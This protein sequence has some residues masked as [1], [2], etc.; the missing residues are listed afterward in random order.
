[1]VQGV[2]G[3]FY[4]GALQNQLIYL[5]VLTSRGSSIPKFSKPNKEY[6]VQDRPGPCLTY[7]H[8]GIKNISL[9]HPFRLF[10]LDILNKFTGTVQLWV[11]TS[12]VVAVGSLLH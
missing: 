1:M 9:W 2:Y 6:H 10:A 7:V 12:D 5:S 3:R 11:G 4:G 8:F